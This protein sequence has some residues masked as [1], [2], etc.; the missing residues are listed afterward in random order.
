MLSI[1]EADGYFDDGGDTIDGS[2]QTVVDDISL[3]GAL[4]AV[5]FEHDGER[6]FIAELEGPNDELLV[7]EIGSITGATAV[8]TEAGEY[9]IDV[10]ADG[11]WS[12]TIAQPFAPD[13]EIRTP[14]VEASGEGHDVVGP[15][16]IDETVTIAGSHD[17]ERNFI[18]QGYDE[19]ASGRLAGELVFNEVGE[20]EGETRADPRGIVWFDVEADGEWT[21]EIGS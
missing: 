14:P 20:F 5:L 6:N 16:E 7:N 19:D 8:P 21:L 4:T 15:V 9:I 18:V 1:Q 17:G 2:G 11:D 10:D 13:E 3:G 12:L